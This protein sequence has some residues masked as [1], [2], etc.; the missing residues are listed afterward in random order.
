MVIMILSLLLGR[1]VWTNALGMSSVTMSLFCFASITQT[2]SSA[3][4]VTVGFA[5]SCFVINLLWM[6][7]F[8]HA[9]ALIVPSYFLV[10]N[11]RLFIALFLSNCVI[12]LGWIGLKTSLLCSCSISALAACFP[13][14]LNLAHCLSYIIV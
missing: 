11:I 12:Y 10:K 7:P 6:L 1:G 2:V 8:A 5:A 9:C 4:V 14:S 3:S 13:F